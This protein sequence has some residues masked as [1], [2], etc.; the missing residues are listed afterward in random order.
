M[1]Y[2]LPSSHLHIDPRLLNL[3]L[4][5][6]ALVDIAAFVHSSHWAHL[7]HFRCKYCR[8]SWLLVEWNHLCLELWPCRYNGWSPNFNYSSQIILQI[9]NFTPL[10]IY[11]H[12][13]H[14]KTIIDVLLPFTLQFHAYKIYLNQLLQLQNGQSGAIVMASNSSD[15]SDRS[16]KPMDQKVLR[17]LAQ[18]REA[19]R[20]SRL[21]K[22]VLL[23]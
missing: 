12:E 11:N 23:P 6:Q 8:E 1:Y 22:K 5:L 9:F 4:C 21:R 7:V 10:E 2:C 17:R 18:N 16:D 19:A 14:K 15:R 20:K 3:F 13:L